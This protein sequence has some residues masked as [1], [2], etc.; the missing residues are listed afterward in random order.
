MTRPVATFK[1]VDS[2]GVCPCVTPPTKL[3]PP[4]GNVFVNGV[5]VMASGDVLTPANGATCSTPS[6]PCV[7]PRVVKSIG[8]SFVNGVVIAKQGDFLN[9]STNITIPTGSPSVFA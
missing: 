6:S 2:G 9:N 8:K 3:G 4:V 1:G 5:A 7:S